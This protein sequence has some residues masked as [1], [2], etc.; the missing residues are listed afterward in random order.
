MVLHIVLCPFC[1]VGRNNTHGLGQHKI[2]HRCTNDIRLQFVQ[3]IDWNRHRHHHKS[4]AQANMMKPYNKISHTVAYVQSFMMAYVW[5]YG[6][7]FET[8]ADA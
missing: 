2:A 7:S 1:S 6:G 3:V 5:S 8:C 4:C